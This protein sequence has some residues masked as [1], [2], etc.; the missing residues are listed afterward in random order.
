MHF[1]QK[2][3]RVTNNYHFHPR[4]SYPGYVLTITMT[5]HFHTLSV[6]PGIIILLLTVNSNGPQ[7]S[8]PMHDVALCFLRRHRSGLR[9]TTP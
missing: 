9:K 2:Y 6:D 8:T 1:I 5:P 7:K 4:Y 3:W